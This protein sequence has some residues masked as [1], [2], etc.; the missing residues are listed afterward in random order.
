MSEFIVKPDDGLGNMLDAIIDRLDGFE[1]GSI[2]PVRSDDA[3]GQMLL[4][5]TSRLDG[6]AFGGKEASYR[7]PMLEPTESLS[8]NQGA[9]AIP[10]SIVEYVDEMFGRVTYGDYN[11]RVIQSTD[12]SSYIERYEVHSVELGSILVI[13]MHCVATNLNQSDVSG[14]LCF[15]MDESESTW[16]SKYGYTLVYEDTSG[17]AHEVTWD[18]NNFLLS[19]IDNDFVVTQSF[20]PLSPTVC[21][22]IESHVLARNYNLAIINNE[23]IAKFSRTY[24]EGTTR[25]IVFIW[26]A[27]TEKHLLTI[28]N[29]NG[30]YA[31]KRSVV[32]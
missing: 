25:Y 30:T 12:D 29:V 14:T 16:G 11:F 1:P 2:W 3:L 22:D 31:Y 10:D 4:G 24:T 13:G 26:E 19:D 5:I 32:S 6:F 18:L 8:P 9:V 7:I 27:P 23:A 15:F 21:A 28:R 20:V 17:A